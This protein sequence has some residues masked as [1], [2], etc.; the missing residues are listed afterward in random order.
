MKNK[1]VIILMKMMFFL[2][3]LFEL[4]FRYLFLLGMNNR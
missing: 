2:I 3:V 1:S 4:D